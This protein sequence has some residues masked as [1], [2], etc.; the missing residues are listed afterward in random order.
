MKILCLYN[1]DIALELFDWIKNEGHRV[2]VFS[3]KLD[4]SWCRE[5]D[6]ELTVS[7]TYRYILSQEIISALNNNV[8]N[9]HISYLPWNCGSDPNIWSILDDTPRGV[10]LHYVDNQLDH[11]DIIAQVLLP[12]VDSYQG[13]K[14][15]TLVSELVNERNDKGDSLSLASTYAELDSA[16]KGL[17]RTALIYYSFWESM[18]KKSC[19]SG[20]YHRCSELKE[21]KNEIYSYDVSISKVREK[22]DNYLAES[23]K[24]GVLWNREIVSCYGAH[25]S[26]DWVEVCAA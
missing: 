5:Q 9:L 24:G 19:H 10:T 18:R 8:V 16:A 11:G 6:F 4:E 26:T 15:D 7:Y 17:F 12:S 25:V 13:E 14:T 3:D 1:N 20:S 22:Y 21:F 2:T 23:G